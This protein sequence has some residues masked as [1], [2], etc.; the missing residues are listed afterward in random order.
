MR[1]VAE[2][3]GQISTE[4]RSFDAF[5]RDTYRRMRAR[6][7][8]IAWDPSEA[9]D[10]VQDAYLELMRAWSRVSLYQSPELWV[11]KVMTQRLRKARTNWFRR[12]ELKIVPPA[13][14]S[15]EETG[16]ARL[17]L[18]AVGTLGLRERQ[19]VVGCCLQ[20]LTQQQV[21]DALEVSRATVNGDLRKARKRLAR[22][23]GL[24]L[25]DDTVSGDA[26]LPAPVRARTS[27]RSSHAAD[28]LLAL[29]RHA[30]SWL[31][32]AAWGENLDEEIVLA[33]LRTR[34]A[35]GN[36]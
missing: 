27:T 17:I 14:A 4:L 12:Q 28:P 1:G 6:A 29:L 36:G 18:D 30:E 20:G 24:D 35:D 25:T 7:L 11:F 16:Q 10:S 8:L 9:E 2:G 32:G 3:G 13:S 5:Y 31:A 15:A 21:A 26:L 23:L 33:D 34:A 19:V 22:K